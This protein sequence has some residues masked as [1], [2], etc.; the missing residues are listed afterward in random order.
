MSHITIR[1]ILFV[2]KVLAWIIVAARAASAQMTGIRSV[3][4]GGGGV[5]RN[6]TSRLHIIVGQGMIGGVVTPLQGFWHTAS[7]LGP[8]PGS[9]VGPVARGAG[10]M[11]IAPNPASHFT[12][13]SITLET[14]SEILVHITDMQGRTLRFLDAGMRDKGRISIPVDVSPLPNGTYLVGV[15]AGESRMMERIVVSR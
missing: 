15:L 8:A 11:T 13:V 3:I 5:L 10:G 14:R 1:R 9:S 12:S 6:A 4:A 7:P 2:A